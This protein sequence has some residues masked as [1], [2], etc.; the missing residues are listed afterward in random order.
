VK[1]KECVRNPRISDAT[2]ASTDRGLS[3]KGQTL[4]RLQEFQLPKR[5]STATRVLIECES[6]AIHR[7]WLYWQKRNSTMILVRVKRSL[8]SLFLIEGEQQVG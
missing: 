7:R 8:G 1:E 2:Q 5:L 6:L 3:A 4:S